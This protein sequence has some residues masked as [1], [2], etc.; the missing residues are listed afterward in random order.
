MSRC[1][2]LTKVVDTGKVFLGGG[3]LMKTSMRICAIFLALM[4]V[5]SVV[6]DCTAQGTGQPSPGAF[7]QT[8]QVS[9]GPYVVTILLWIDSPTMT[10][11]GVR[12]EIDPGRDAR[13]IIR[14]GRTLVPVRAVLEELGGGISWHDADK[15]ASITLADIAIELWI[16]RSTASVN[17]VSRPIDP[18]NPR[19]VLEIVNGRTMVPLRFV[20]ESLGAKVAWNQARREI[21][22]TF[23]QNLIQNSSRTIALTVKQG[24]TAIYRVYLRNPLVTDVIVQILLAAQL[25]QG[26]TA[27]FCYG[28]ICYFKTAEITLHGHEQKIIELSVRTQGTGEGDALLFVSSKEFGDDGFIVHVTS[29]GD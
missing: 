15:R 1:S 27:E 20:A 12:H 3:A 13:P 18:T 10:V 14:D 9:A 5:L 6:A 11:D 4:Q 24:D 28:D 26:W 23:E 22:L 16:G 25:P 8:A 17:G 19:V 21:S 2:V 29:T 7:S